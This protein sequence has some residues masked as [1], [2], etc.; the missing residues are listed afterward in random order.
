MEGPG[1][2]VAKMGWNYQKSIFRVEVLNYVLCN[3]S[4]I[5][6]FL[7]FQY[8]HLS[9]IFDGDFVAQIL[10]PLAE[11]LP[12]FARKIDAVHYTLSAL[13]YHSYRPDEE[14]QESCSNFTEK[15]ALLL[16]T[17]LRF[18]CGISWGGSDPPS[19]PWGGLGRFR[20]SLW[21][22][23]LGLKCWNFFFFLPNSRFS[24]FRFIFFSLSHDIFFV[25]RLTSIFPQIWWVATPLPLYKPLGYGMNWSPALLSL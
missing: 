5:K 22:Q 2:P 10:P 12:H 23:T 6:I 24:H 9:S 16:L 20:G 19:L 14:L 4:I 17:L 7:H 1:I 3:F 15:V 21:V 11:K 18:M 8:E 25:F 13:R